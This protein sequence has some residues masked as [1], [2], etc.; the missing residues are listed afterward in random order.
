MGNFMDVEIME[1]E[2]EKKSVIW[3]E[4]KPSHILSGNY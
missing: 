4:C 3:C 2:G 1:G